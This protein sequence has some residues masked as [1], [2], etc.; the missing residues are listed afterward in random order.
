MKKLISMILAI[1]LICAGLYIGADQLEK[2][3]GITGENS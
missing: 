3:K 1:L 2:A